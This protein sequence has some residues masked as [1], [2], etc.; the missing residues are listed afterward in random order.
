MLLKDILDC[1]LEGVSLE[2]IGKTDA[3]PVVHI[4]IRGS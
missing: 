4:V 3:I 1:H 2:F